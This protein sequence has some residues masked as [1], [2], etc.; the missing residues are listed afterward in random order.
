MKQI[1]QEKKL[2][3]QN[4][5]L[6]SSEDSGVWVPV[7]TPFGLGPRDRRPFLT[8]SEFRSFRT[9][10]LIFRLAILTDFFSTIAD[11]Q[12]KI[13]QEKNLSISLIHFSFGPIVSSLDDWFVRLQKRIFFSERI[14]PQISKTSPFRGS[15]GNNLR[16]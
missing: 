1:F 15:G 13:L 14:S 4:L 12:D 3:F 6:S 8:I 16:F 9:I 11:F 10:L 5:Q 7:L 2:K